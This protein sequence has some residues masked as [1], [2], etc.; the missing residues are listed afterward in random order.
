MAGGRPARSRPAERSALEAAREAKYREIKDAELD[1]STG[2]LS[3][4]DYEQLSATLRAEA[5][6]ILDRL[7]A[8][9]SAT[10]E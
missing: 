5:V 10:P 4:E 8:L 3:R 2:K 1:F 6:E 9:G 7:T